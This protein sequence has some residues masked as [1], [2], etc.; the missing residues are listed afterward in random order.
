LP[1]L[2]GAAGEIAP[3]D[4]AEGREVAV[5][6]E[7]GL[8]EVAKGGGLG[9]TGEADFDSPFEAF[10]VWRVGAGSAIAAF[11]SAGSATAAAC[12]AWGVDGPCCGGEKQQRGEELA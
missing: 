10:R 7:G 2:E 3:V 4:L 5:E 1:L 6:F 9:I 12:A 11:F 8:A